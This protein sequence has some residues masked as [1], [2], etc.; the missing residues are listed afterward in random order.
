MSFSSHFC[1]VYDVVSIGETMVRYSPAGHERLE[2]AH[3][4]EVHVGGSESN[5][6]AGLSRLGMG[7]CWISRL[8]KSPMGRCIASA[9]ASHGVDTRWIRWTESDRVGVYYYEPGT[10]SRPSEVIYDRAHSAF[11]KMRLDELPTSPLQ[12][13]KLLHLTGISLALADSVR[14]TCHEARRIAM[15]AGA[16]TSFDFN[17]RAK[18]WSMADARVHCTEWI[19]QSEL[20]FIALRDASEWLGTAERISEESVF[21]RLLARRVQGA[22]IMTL[23]SNGAIASDGRRIVRQGTAAV[24]GPGRLGAG[25]AF[26][27]GFLYGWLQSWD[28]E[29]CLRWA[30]SAARNKFST[31]GDLPWFTGEELERSMEQEAGNR[32]IR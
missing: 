25:D 26:S 32:L 17:Y 23:G 4:L 5:T 24:D 2:Q 12:Q 22:T 19:E 11:S 28:I 16:K 8:P 10:E 30:N 6:M 9:L 27:A 14:E 1:P 31:P 21:A 18:L 29:R 15:A 20:V 7:T 13:T 3:H